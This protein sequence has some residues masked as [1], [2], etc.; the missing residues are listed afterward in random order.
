MVR[1]AIFFAAVAILAPLTE[2]A[3]N[4]SAQNAQRTPIQTIL[5]VPFEAAEATAASSRYDWLGE[6]VAGLGVT[7]LSDE[8]R[9]VFSRQQFQAAAERFGLPAAYGSSARFTRATLLKLAEQLDAD[10]VVFGRYEVKDK[11]LRL[12]ARVIRLEPMS[13][14]EKLEESGSLEDF[15]ALHAQLCWKVL[16]QVDSAYPFSRQEFAQRFAKLRLEALENYVRGQQVS[17]DAE[18]LRL[19]R[20]AAQVEPEWSEPAY[21]LGMAYFGVKDYANAATWLSR[22]AM[23]SE[24]GREAAFYGGL[25]QYLRE[26]F[27]RAES[28]WAALVEFTRTKVGGPRVEVL[29]NLALVRARLEKREE[30]VALLQRATQAYPEDTELWIN[31]GLVRLRF[32]D[33]TQSRRAFR[34][35]VRLAPE[36]AAARGLYVFSLEQS[37]RT[38]EATAERESFGQPLPQ[39]SQAT[40]V[41]FERVKRALE[42]PVVA[43]DARGTRLTPRRA[44]NLRRH[45]ADGQNALAKQQWPEAERNF[46]A[47]IL[48]APDARE[49]H[50]GLAEALTA[51]NRLEEAVREWRAALFV[52]DDAETRLRL[53]KVFL[54]FD[55]QRTEEARAELR[56]ALRLNPAGKLRDEARRML[57]EANAPAANGVRP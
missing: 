1:R 9:A 26:D 7:R 27:A 56:A 24:F 14:S 53:A 39:V 17:E 30:A 2:A 11:S 28:T 55:P 31:L 33:W 44:Q 13:Q 15:S 6:A 42:E 35:A 37:G 47:A 57:E 23:S 51:Q 34:E 22:V 32:D 46:A 36:D 18:R 19:W 45:L 50:V 40:L 49:A 25:G 41:S 16:R 52:R 38:T 10:F 29:N 5:I 43:A 8:G 4:S 48:L 20:T 12:E 3:G 21:A 54:E